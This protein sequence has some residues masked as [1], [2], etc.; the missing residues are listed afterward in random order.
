MAQLKDTVVS[1]NLRVTDTVLAE[2]VETDAIKVHESSSSDEITAGENGQVLAT[3]GNKAY[4]EDVYTKTQADSTFATKS[5][6][7]TIDSVPTSGSTNAVSSGGVYNALQNKVPFSISSIGNRKYVDTIDT[8]YINDIRMDGNKVSA[9]GTNVEIENAAADTVVSIPLNHSGNPTIAFKDEIPIVDATPTES[10]TNAVS[11]GGVYTELLDV[12]HQGDLIGSATYED[13]GTVVDLTDYVREDNLKTINNQ[14]LIGSGNITISGGGSADLSNYVPKSGS[15]TMS[16][17]AELVFPSEDWDEQNDTG[18]ATKISQQGVHSYDPDDGSELHVDATD[19]AFINGSY[20][21][22]H[23]SYG[24]GAINYHPSSS[25]NYTYSFPSKSGTFALTSDVPDPRT[26]P[27]TITIVGQNGDYNVAYDFNIQDIDEWIRNGSTVFLIVEQDELNPTN[28][29]LRGTFPLVEID[30]ANL[31]L[32]FCAGK[33]NISLEYIVEENGDVNKSNVTVYISEPFQNKI[34][35]LATIRSNAAAGAAKVSNVQSD[36]NATSGLAQILNKPTLATVATSGSYNDLSNK[37]TIPSAVTE[38]TVSGWGFTKNTGTYS[39]PSGGIPKTD[40]ASAVQTSLGKADT[41][42]QSYTET[43]PTVPAW[44]K[45]ATKPTYTAAEVGA[46]PDTTVIPATTSAL[47]NDS[48]F[49][50]I[51]ISS[52]EPTSSD[53]NNGDIWI[54]I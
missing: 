24:N 16:N 8:L 41:A 47:T 20:S 19:M 6:L 5:Q 28:E 35:D 33:Y 30:Y 49:K 39:K 3:D 31:I 43:D 7:P 45:A 14:S 9:N 29:Y 32:K 11:S 12:V 4:W 44:A 22:Q 37:P 18:Y 34:S 2:V 17:D 13:S 10:S 38:S 51:T 21:G 53:G 25:S 54:V 26:L 50:K 36:W 52:S 42:L 23:T 15:T 1:G 40:L 27:Y 48:G 46:L